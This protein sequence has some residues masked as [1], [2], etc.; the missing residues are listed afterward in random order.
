MA[1]DDYRVEHGPAIVVNITANHP[2][3][4]IA[5][6]E[7]MVV[8]ADINIYGVNPDVIKEVYARVVDLLNRVE[9]AVVENVSIHPQLRGGQ[10]LREPESENYRLLAFLSALILP[11]E[12]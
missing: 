2:Y 11:V 4:E 7:V 5:S 8:E 1:D 10:I 3:E 9:S 12:G 6:N